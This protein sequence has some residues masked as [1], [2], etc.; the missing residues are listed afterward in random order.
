MNEK[1]NVERRRIR[2]KK[3][4]VEKRRMRDD[5]KSRTKAR[6]RASKTE[7]HMRIVDD[8]RIDTRKRVNTETSV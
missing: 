2:D 1:K 7:K 8:T 4:N 3:K 5:K 6:T